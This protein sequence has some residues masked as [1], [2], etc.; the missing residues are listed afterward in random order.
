[1]SQNNSN[2]VSADKYGMVPQ[3]LPPYPAGANSARSASLAMQEQSVNKQMALIGKGGSRRKRFWKGGAAAQVV[4]P[5]VNTPYPD[6]GN[7]TANNFKSTTQA[8]INQNAQSAFDVCVGKGA[9]CTA[10]VVQE[11]KAGSRRTT[12]RRT[13]KSKKKSR[14][15]RFSKKGGFKWGCMSGGKKRYTNKR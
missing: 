8:T 10:Q 7:Q 1:M 4:V 11:Q 12:K 3:Q 2:V 6:I 15:T 9:G 13:R 14:K 5:P